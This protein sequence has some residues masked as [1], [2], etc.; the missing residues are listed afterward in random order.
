MWLA[1]LLSDLP[2]I[3]RIYLLIRSNR[4]TTSLARFQRDRRGIA[5]FR[6]LAERH[7]DGFAQFL[8]ERIE[9][10]DGDVSKPGL[11][12]TPTFASG[13]AARRSDREQ[14]GANGF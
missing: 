3:G 14:F 2:E 12:L 1:N 13:F 9:V 6:G 10:V 11:G 8:H 4:S 7:G 5:G